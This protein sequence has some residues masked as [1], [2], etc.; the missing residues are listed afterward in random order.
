MGPAAA[1]DVAF[2]E[3]GQLDVRED[4]ALLEGL[5][6]HPDAGSGEIVAGVEGQAFVGQGPGHALGRPSA[7]GAD[8]D[9]VPLPE[10]LVDLLHQVLGPTHDRVPPLGRDGRRLRTLGR[11][12]QM[13]DRCRRVRQQTV[14]REVQ[15]RKA[16]LGAD[17]AGVDGT[18]AG[19]P[20]A[21]QRGG[22]R[23]LLVE[24]LSGPVAHAAR[25]DEQR[26]SAS[27]P[28]RSMHD[29]LAVGQPRQPGLHAVEDQALGQPLPLLTSP[30]LRPAKGRWPAP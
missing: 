7:L 29:L 13:P 26:P 14:E 9:P 21:G 28:S 3:H 15:P 25:L 22:Q 20:G 16:R 24:E 6:D 10:V 5:H 1:R 23:R 8:H 18:G 11:V 17:G 19:P 12:G 4:E 27:G 2:G 30:G